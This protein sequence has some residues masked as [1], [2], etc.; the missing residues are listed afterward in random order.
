MMWPSG[1]SVRII[2]QNDCEQCVSFRTYLD[3]AGYEYEYYDAERPDI[4]EQLDEW[5]IKDMP[6]LQI[7][8]D[9]KIIHQFLPGL[10]S[11][12]TILSVM[13]KA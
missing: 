8:K 5:L 12:K 11:T 1:F 2:G 7:L 4:Q 10:K 3:S 13:G 9:G 6:V